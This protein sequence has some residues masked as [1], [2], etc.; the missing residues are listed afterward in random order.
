MKNHA[1]IAA[2]QSTPTDV[3]GRDVAPPEESERHER[4]ADARLDHEEE[5]ERARVRPRAV[6]A[7]ARTVQPAWLPLTI[8]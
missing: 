7:S 4:R 5:R 3:R 6:R 1:N 2:A 8:A